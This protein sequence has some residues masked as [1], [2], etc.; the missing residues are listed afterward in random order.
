MCREA[1]TINVCRSVETSQ[2]IIVL[3]RCVCVCVS[4]RYGFVYCGVKTDDAYYTY[5]WKGL[6]AVGAKQGASAA[7][8]SV[9]EDRRKNKKSLWKAINICVPCVRAFDVQPIT[10]STPKKRGKKV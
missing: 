2:T 5:T 9:N 10:K 6:L 3:C 1:V 7:S 4:A 8:S